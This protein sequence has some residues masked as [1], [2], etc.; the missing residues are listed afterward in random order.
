MNNMLDKRNYPKIL[1]SI[2]V[3][4]ILKCI[5]IKKFRIF[6]ILTNS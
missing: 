1:L 6:F 4:K 2:E 3:A 5:N